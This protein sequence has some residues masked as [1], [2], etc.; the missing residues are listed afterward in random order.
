[1]NIDESND[2]EIQFKNDILNYKGYF[3]ENAQ[4]DD[5]PKY[6]EFGAH[7]SY[8]ELYKR[9]EIVQK[10]QLM[11][12]IEKGKEKEKK[13]ELKNIKIQINQKYNKKIEN[14]ERNNTKNK[15]IENK[16]NKVNNN[17]K[18]ENKE[19]DNFQN[20]LNGFRPKI[21]SRNI[22]CL[23]APDDPNKN[24]NELTFI[25]FS[26]KI[27]NLS[28]KK[29][30]KIPNKS[31]SSNNTNYIKIYS[32]NK[33][34][35]LL[36]P[37][38]DLINKKITNYIHNSNNNNNTNNNNKNNPFNKKFKKKNLNFHTQI[39]KLSDKQVISR[40][41]E[42]KN[43][44]PQI[45]NIHNNQTVNSNYN[46][47]TINLTE[48]NYFQSYQMQFK[49]KPKNNIYKKIFI[50][51]DS[52]FNYNSKENINNNKNIFQNKMKQLTE[53]KFSYNSLK[54]HIDTGNKR[55]RLNKIINNSSSYINMKNKMKGK[56]NNNNLN[57][58]LNSYNSKKMKFSSEKKFEKVLP[59]SQE[60]Y[61][62]SYKNN[63][64]NL[65]RNK[66]EFYNISLKKNKIN[67]FSDNN[68]YK[69]FLQVSK[70]NNRK[71]L[72]NYIKARKL[73]DNHNKKQFSFINVNNNNITYQGALNINKN[74]YLTKENKKLNADLNNYIDDN[75]KNE[76][77]ENLNYDKINKSNKTNNN[78]DIKDL[79]NITGKNEKISRNKNKSYFINN[80]SSINYSHN[81]I[82]N[83]TNSNININKSINNNKNNIKKMNKTQQNNAFIQYNN[84]KNQLIRNKIFNFNK[85]LIYDNNKKISIEIPSLSHKKIFTT[86][87]EDNSFINNNNYKSKF[88]NKKLQYNKTNNYY[89]NH[90][91]INK[92]KKKLNLTKDIIYQPKLKLNNI[93]KNKNIDLSLM[94]NNIN[95][96]NI[97]HNNINH[98][99][100]SHNNNDISLNKNNISKNINLNQISNINNLGNNSYLIKKFE[101]ILQ[102]KSPKKSIN[103]N[104]NINNNNRIIYN[105]IF[106]NKS[107]L[108]KNS[109]H[110]H[111]KSPILQKNVPQIN[112][113]SYGNASNL[114]IKKRKKS[115][116]KIFVDNL[117]K[118]NGKIP[119][120][121]NIQF[122]KTKLLN[123]SHKNNNI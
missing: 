107:P 80:I 50:L 76:N 52:S 41:R 71:N 109:I 89:L 57:N 78:N 14:K 95:H 49:N 82:I 104:I 25:P 108:L 118:N 37:N 83:S 16:S 101:N 29:E 79:F 51:N 93:L 105:K 6:F 27:N 66:N 103:I 86:S 34:K 56:L 68:E 11:K 100:I 46:N 31:I 47:I 92:S 19:N 75:N 38:N 13:D 33:K 61:Y 58:L 97:N 23:G 94:N 64:N 43:L 70:E 85:K 59:N 39:N 8:K 67:E 10:E 1:M 112:N 12:E 40:N 21:R 116:G 15:R 98:N 96:N 20:I 35:K 122:P 115:S 17:T 69:K 45:H 102:K 65:I 32:N 7:F 53:P 30:Q 99:N 9:L 117:R 84:P 36:N 87:T 90:S 73:D 62:F 5:D 91:I 26:N 18:K 55:M 22:G 42:Q 121:N 44:Y 123:I 48:M 106:E 63:Y 3:V 114:M 60:N 77:S 74:N 24:E 4:E 81:K 28:V 54:K 113:T 110:K 119:N 72:L 88:I 2:E 120:F 111:V